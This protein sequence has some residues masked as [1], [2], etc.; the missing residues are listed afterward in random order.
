MHFYGK[1]GYQKQRKKLANACQ[2][3]NICISILNM[4]TNV[5][6]IRKLLNLLTGSTIPWSNWFYT[7]VRVIS[8]NKGYE[9]FDQ[10]LTNLFI[11]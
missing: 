2:H 6:D 1:N 11:D 3:K 8:F 4:H 10:P 9:F 7:I 5:C